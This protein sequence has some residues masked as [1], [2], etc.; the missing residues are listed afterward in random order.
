MIVSAFR[1]ED[2]L[3]RFPWMNRRDQR[4]VVGT[5]LDALVSS[6]LAHHVLG[7]EIAGFYD[8]TSIH[9]SADVGTT[10][11][12]ADAVWLDLDISRPSVRSV[13]H[14]ILQMDDGPLDAHIQTLNPN[15][16][17]GVTVQ[18]YGRKYPLATLH[19]LLWLW[20]VDPPADDPRA[21]PL[22]WLPDS[23]FINGQSDKRDARGR[24]LQRHYRANVLDWLQN[25]VPVPALVATAAEIDT[26][27][28]EE[29]VAALLAD[30]AACGWPPGMGRPPS[31]HLGLA[32]GQ[33]RFSRPDPVRLRRI[34]RTISEI[35]GWSAPI[36]P[37]RFVSLTGRRTNLQ[38]AAAVSPATN[39]GLA[40]FLE[41]RRV[42][43]YALPYRDQINFTVFG[44]SS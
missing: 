28:F 5:D 6:V 12:L 10:R 7:W 16:L 22:L 37:D 8:L 43:S 24:I 13:G 2:V 42:F 26:R 15:L 1:R 31:N 29:R 33:C 9:R 30:F 40:D 20:N 11:E 41:R 32:G 21:L 38:I 25:G 27:A 18:D 36:C 17:R 34:Y 23:S 19:L 14:H 35:T 44:P 39:A 4:M 3:A